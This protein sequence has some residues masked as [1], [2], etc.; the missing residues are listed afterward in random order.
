MTTIDTLARTAALAHLTRESLGRLALFAERRSYRREDCLWREGDEARELVVVVSGVVKTIRGGA[1]QPAVCSLLGASESLDASA[2]VGGL[3]HAT[4]AVVVSARS[5]IVALPREAL[6]AEIE[7]QPTCLLG[8][9][10]AAAQ[11]AGLLLDKIDVLSAGSVEARL[12]ALLLKLN[13]RFGDDFED[14][15]N[16]IPVVLSRRDLAS[17]VATSLE[18]VIRVMSRWEREGVLNTTRRGF[19]LRDL[20]RLELLSGGEAPV[21]AE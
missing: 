8:F 21:A 19:V 5:V 4:D 11:H 15:T 17:L 10:R 1:R 13:G 18:T 7:A 9:L 20:G 6:M 2:V 3:P 16:Q 12:A 14:G